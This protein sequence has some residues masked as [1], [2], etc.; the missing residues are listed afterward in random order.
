M[1]HVAFTSIIRNASPPLG[2]MAT[3]M[4][5]L[6]GPMIVDHITNFQAVN[7]IMNTMLEDVFGEEGFL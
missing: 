7:D 2:G 4:T 5:N 6:H 3:L 1:D